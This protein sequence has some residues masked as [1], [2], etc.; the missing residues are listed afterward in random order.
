MLLIFDALI[1]CALF[2]LVVPMTVKVVDETQKRQ[3]ETQV[4][5]KKHREK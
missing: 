1:I 3:I 2:H 5:Q 4:A